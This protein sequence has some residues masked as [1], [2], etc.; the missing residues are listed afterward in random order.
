MPEL[1]RL[2][3]EVGRID[4]GAKKWSVCVVRREPDRLSSTEVE[5]GS[6]DYCEGRQQTN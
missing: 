1:R 4:R 5:R 3:P 6:Y 2:L